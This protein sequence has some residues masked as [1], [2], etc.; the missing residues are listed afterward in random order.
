M[1]TLYIARQ[2]PE[3]H[4]WRAV[5]RLTREDGLYFFEYTRG[6]L[7]SPGFYLGRMRDLYK[8][9]HSRDLFPLFTNRLLNRSRPDYP[10]YVRWLGVDENADP[11]QL[12]SRSGG[13]RATDN[14]C[15]YPHPEPN[16]KGEIELFFFSHGLRYLDKE[17]L[18]RIENLE[19]RE[20]L[21]F[22][23]ED[24]NSY[25]RFA[26]VV[27][28]G[29]PVKVGYCPRYLN[30]DLRNVIAGTDVKLRAEQV[31]KEAPM[32]FRLLCKAF[33]TLPQ[34]FEL[35]TTQEYRPLV[36]GQTAAA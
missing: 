22:R 31:N 26:L 20:R 1:T 5:G 3:S 23:P 21:Q 36:G 16:E 33:F 18:Q 19:P 35:F 30:Q 25:D 7:E 34:Q 8:R 2:D 12:L 24:D 17:A 13:K 10:A 28:T 15:V 11:M 32:Q 9:Y 6:A 27:Q 4:S 29:D 14:L